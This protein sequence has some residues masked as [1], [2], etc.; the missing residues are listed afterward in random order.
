MVSYRDMTD[1]ERV[2]YAHQSMLRTAERERLYKEKTK[3]RT[4]RV[5]NCVKQVDL[6]KGIFNN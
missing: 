3:N 2:E 6:P 4:I 1:K 5:S